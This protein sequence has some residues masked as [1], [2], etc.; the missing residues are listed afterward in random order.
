MSTLTLSKPTTKKALI[1]KLNLIGFE[2][3]PVIRSYINAGVYVL[4]PDALSLL[5]QGVYCDMP[6]LYEKLIKN[7]NQVI[8][9]LRFFYFFTIIIL[10]FVF[11]IRNKRNFV[12]LT[13]S[14]MME[15]D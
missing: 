8:K 14:D 1:E 11:L 12:I 10:Q 3:K 15:K 2:E 9:I 13:V 7:I 6:S 5:V 4:N